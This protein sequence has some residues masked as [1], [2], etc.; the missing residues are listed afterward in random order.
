MEV[1][2]VKVSEFY[3]N[4]NNNNNNNNDNNLACIA[5]VCQRL[6]RRNISLYLRNGAR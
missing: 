6:Q 5:S 3:N 4:N 2:K 1:R